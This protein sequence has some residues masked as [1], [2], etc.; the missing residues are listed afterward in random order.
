M[1]REL[2]VPPAEICQ[3]FAF[4]YSRRFDLANYDGM[5]AAG[6]SMHNAAFE[7]SECAFQQRRPG[8]ALGV[9]RAVETILILR[10][11]PPGEVFLILGQNVYREVRSLS[12]AAMHGRT[13]VYTSQDQRRFQRHGRKGTN[14]HSHR[15]I[16]IA[17]GCN[18]GYAADEA[19]QRSAELVCA[20]WH[21]CLPT[22]Y[23]PSLSGRRRV[24]G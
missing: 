21:H 8:H 16:V 24:I 1:L 18:N 2:G 4:G 15:P 13:L 5:I 6:I 7:V 22:S 14:G 23:L 10:G 20:Y 19:A 9:Q 11:E 3:G 17:S 12:K